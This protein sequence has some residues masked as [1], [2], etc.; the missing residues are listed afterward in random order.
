MLSNVDFCLWNK[1]ELVI[2]F[3]A[4]IVSFKRWFLVDQ[5]SKSSTTSL[6]LFNKTDLQVDD[7]TAVGIGNNQDWER[8]Q[9]QSNQFCHNPYMGIHSIVKNC[10]CRNTL[11]IFF[12][13]VAAFLKIFFDSYRHNSEVPSRKYCNWLQPQDFFSALFN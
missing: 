1:P 5:V 2:Q 9:N 13:R 3:V 12:V 4:R 8:S 10:S 7:K 11:S 6:C